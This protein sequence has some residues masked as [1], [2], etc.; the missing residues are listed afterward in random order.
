MTK[1]WYVT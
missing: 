1:Q